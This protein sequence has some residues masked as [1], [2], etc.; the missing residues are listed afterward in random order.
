MPYGSGPIIRQAL[1][2]A[3]PWQ[4]SLIG[5]AMVAGGVVFVLVG[6]VA[7]GLLAVAGVF[8]LFGMVRGRLRGP[9]HTAGSAP[10]DG[11]T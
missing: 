2:R 1:V 4:R 10:R 8:L 6:H 3:S 11:R 7:G 9:R 5:V